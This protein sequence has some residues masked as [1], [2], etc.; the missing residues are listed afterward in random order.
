MSVKGDSVVTGSADHGLREYNLK[1]LKYKRELYAKKF[2]H[3]EWVTSVDHCSDG[4]I[5][6]GGMDSKLCL[7]GKSGARCDHIMGHNGSISK[8]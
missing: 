4:R 3:A 7:W 1:S 8:V 6:S 5:L 2:G